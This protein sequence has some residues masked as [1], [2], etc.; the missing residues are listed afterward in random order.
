MQIIELEKEP[1]K[2]KAKTSDDQSK[3]TEQEAK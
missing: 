1:S 3:K 2:D